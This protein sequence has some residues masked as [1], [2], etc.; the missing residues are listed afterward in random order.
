MNGNLLLLGTRGSDL[1]LKQTSIVTE[2]LQAAH[3]EIAVSHTVIQ[4]TGDKRQDLKLTEFGK[5]GAGLVD[6]GIFIKELEVALEKKQIDAA[7][8]SLKD[9]PS[10]LDPVFSVAA[11]LERAPI[12]DVLISRGGYT[13]ETLPAGAS[14]GT[15]SV[16]RSRQLK[17][18][19]PDVNIVEL[20]GNVPTRVRKCLGEQPLDAIL[21]AAAGL[22]RLDLL[23]MKTG[24]I[25][26]DGETLHG[27]V[28]D[29]RKF[30]PAAGQGAI[31]IEVRARDT[32]TRGFIRAINHAETEARILAEREFLRIL[33]AGCQT[34]VGAYTWIE[35]KKLHMTVRLFSETNLRAEPR[36]ATAAFAVDCPLTLAKRLAATVMP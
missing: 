21:L 16:R 24:V 20:R 1:A 25:S 34:P 4:T 5:G 11:V 14:V 17:Y 22:V 9:L 7:V 29:P 3:F 12:E 27:E 32:Q 23:D 2:L 30:L 6:K 33:G 26:I 36:E 19:R 28:L 31:A 35:G 8:H 18:L 13:I 10:E 15:S